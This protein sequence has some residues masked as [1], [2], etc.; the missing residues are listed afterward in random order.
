M[1]HSFWLEASNNALRMLA[2]LPHGVRNGIV[3]NI[4]LNRQIFPVLTACVLCT[5][6]KFLFLG[7]GP[8]AEWLS[9]RTPLWGQGFASWDPG[10]GPSTAHQAVL[11]WRPT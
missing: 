8:V 6:E 2:S 10:H 3:S 5:E 11:R 4:H 1:S 7:A 9:S